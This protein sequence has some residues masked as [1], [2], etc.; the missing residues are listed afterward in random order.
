M[1]APIHIDFTDFINAFDIPQ[2]SIKQFVSNIV[3]ELSTEFAM[4]WGKEADS[5]GS[6]RQQYKQGIYAEKVDD[7]NFIVGLN[8]WLPN[9]IEQ[10]ISGFDMKEGFRKSSKVIWS[11]DK[12]KDKETG[13]RSWYLTIPFRHAT[14][15]A[16]G[17]SEVFSGVMPSEV[18][19]E[20]KT[21]S[22]GEGLNVKNLPKEFQVKKTRA[23]VI[24]KSKTFDEYQAKHSIHLGIQKK[25][26]ST[27]RG[28][29][30][31]FRRVSDKSDSNSWIH[32]G[33]NAKNLAEKAFN[34]MDI[35]ATVD[36]LVE[37]YIEQL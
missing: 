13:E 22:P 17:E 28:T 18:Y 4:Y 23:K 3:S 16:I 26:D 33:F 32:K 34:K 21:L 6:T 2:E 20:A 29:Y 37:K 10:G 24:T 25:I 30:V 27:G 9:A 19:K 31:S 8:G 12:D 7:F 35:P 5:L 36:I 11:I 1:L 14:S 15:G